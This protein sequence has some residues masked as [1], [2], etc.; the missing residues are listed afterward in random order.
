[1]ANTLAD[2]LLE[3]PALR[4]DI[5][6]IT[7][8]SVAEQFSVLTGI[9]EDGATTADLNYLLE[10][11]SVLAHSDRGACQDAALRIAHFTLSRTQATV[12]QRN[13]AAL[14][15]EMMTNRSAVALA[16]QRG[17]VESAYR[18]EI[19]P[20]LLLDAL[21]RDVEF[22]LVD[23][24]T[25]GFS[26]VNRFQMLVY[27]T[28]GE[29]SWLSISAPTSSGKSFILQR[30]VH[31]V[32]TS[33]D[34]HTV[35]YV[36]PTRALVQELEQELRSRFA[37]APN[38]FITSIPQ[39]PHGSV[40]APV[41]YVLT[42]E[43]LQLLLTEHADFAPDVL[44]VDEAQKIGEGP[45][46]I[47][48]EQVIDQVG[49]RKADVRTVFASP[50][51]SNPQ[52]LLDH[53]PPGR[54][55]QSV[56]AE[57]VAVNQNLIWVSQVPRK[58]K[59]WTVELCINEETLPLGQLDLPQTPSPE[60]KRLP[61]IAAA[62]GGSIGGNL[63]YV[64]GAADAEKTAVQLAE[65][66]RATLSNDPEL[67]ALV[68]LVQRTVHEKYALAAVLPYGVAFHYGNMPLLIRSEIERLF[69]SGKIRFLVC[70][71]TLI[72][73][74]NLPARSIFVRGPQKGKGKPMGEMDFWNLAGRAGRQGKE[75]QGNVICIDPRNPHIWK[76]PP[77]T[78]RLRYVIER[79][80]D[81][82]FLNRRQEL[83]DYIAAGTPRGRPKEYDPLEYA[84]VYFLGERIRFGSLAASPRMAK[85]DL[86]IVNELDAACATGMAPVELP[87][88]FIL[89]N[90]GVSP[91]AQQGLLE[92]LRAKKAI[93]EAIP[94]EPGSDDALDSYMRVI[95]IISQHLSGDP[96]QLTYPHALLVV[97]WM[98]GYSLARLI[99]ENW[100]YWKDHGRQL[101]DVIRR[102]MADI[103]EYA[104]FRF[105]KYSAC[106][107]DVLRFHLTELNRVDLVEE[108]PRLNMWLEFGT[109]IATQLSLIGL[110]LSRTSAIAVSEY[111][112]ED[113][114]D[115]E[116]ALARL[117]ELNL[118]TV[119][120][121]PIIA[122]EIRRV[123]G[124][125]V[126]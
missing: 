90:P 91:I 66:F 57:Q 120:V 63:V 37:G 85:Y 33:A 75:F 116:A 64:S 4:R 81:R 17:L 67:A 78:R 21:R 54:K 36:V 14:I 98:R 102:T 2:R 94:A 56:A 109:S 88:E 10:C 77:P 87:T 15:L 97:N 38:V 51:T 12:P 32:I 107:V 44:V 122:N 119:A 61:M 123:R 70:T 27:R 35:V 58:A 82:V 23:T 69:R 76:E 9:P 41:V 6:R 72:E 43:R 86:A 31:D 121:S 5:R 42:Q 125:A 112:P 101:P 48:L 50:M 26:Q 47:L 80:T 104:R 96:L 1:M 29:G 28:F 73:G 103:E 110:G 114:L 111:I 126:A 52:V 60:S 13:G 3:S 39:V 106:Y 53:A 74:V 20:P 11:G 108:I 92:Y 89:R 99:S 118:D 68:D 34:A 8:R 62:L 93:E 24:T 65:M 100:K 45:R 95:G 71:S 7:L 18:D 113:N 40:S 49:Q 46:G 117:R 124:D 83:L 30:A 19:P 59:R 105:A 79:A 84:F 115:L 22:S 55:T 16:V 25:G